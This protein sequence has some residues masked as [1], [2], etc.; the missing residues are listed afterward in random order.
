MPVL[1][2]FDLEGESTQRVISDKEM[3]RRWAKFHGDMHQLSGKWWQRLLGR[4]LGEDTW[5]YKTAR[6]FGRPPLRAI[7][8]LRARPHR[9]TAVQLNVPLVHDASSVFPKFYSPKNALRY[10]NASLLDVPLDDVE[11]VVID[12]EGAPSAASIITHLN[13][14]LHRTTKTWLLISD[15]TS[16]DN[17][18]STALKA[19]MSAVRDTDEIVFADE[20]GPNVFKPIFRSSSVA[21]HTL[22]SFNMVGR[23]ALLRVATLIAIGGFDLDA[24]WAFEHDA[25]L[26]LLERRASFH[27]VSLVLPSGR[28]LIAFDSSHIDG[29]TCRVVQRAL[30]RRG[31]TG[32]VT[33]G[34]LA[35]LV[36]WRLS[37]PTPPPSIDIIIPTRDRIDLV[38]Q[39][40]EAVEEKTTYENYD[41]ILLDNDSVEPES[42]EYFANSKY[43]VVPCPGPFNY[44]KIVN[45]GV[46]HSS[47]DFV[48][49]LNNDTIL[50]TPD[51]LE[52][53]VS[54]ASLADVGIVGACLF[55]Q[56]GHR[57][58]ES[59]IISPYPQHLRTD[60]N[61]PHVDQFSL[62]VRDVAAVTGAVQLVERSFWDSLG[63]MDERLAVTMNDVDLCLRAQSDDHYVVYT[64]DVQL[65][66]HVSSSRGTLDPLE[67]R[68]RFIRRWDIF[69]TFKDP[70]FP[71]PLLLLGE[72]M[73]YLPR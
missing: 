71:Q 54:L 52:Q 9:A 44:A 58:H 72:T 11:I 4:I 26:R 63:G 51:W 7:R 28:P 27:H 66:H 23:P 18:R 38:K 13:E 46:A 10:V 22:L 29:D 24:G 36:S 37:P 50:Q 31:L 65:V 17:D 55:D 30:A 2:R 6:F 40:I 64:P 69:G 33:P 34:A 47:A 1:Q 14:T 59:I 43:R 8:R 41:I 57:E 15:V 60:S 42:L 62:A 16:D 5:R 32:T 53:M 39:C 21:P 12:E 48:L 45:R 67:D 19:L 20:S 61:Y 73:Y 56:Y 68:N 35:G 49:T 70:F 25:Y 3:K